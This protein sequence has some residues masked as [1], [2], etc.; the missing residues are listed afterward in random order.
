M[1]GSALTVWALYKC[2]AREFASSGEISLLVKLLGKSSTS[3]DNVGHACLA[4][5]EDILAVHRK[6]LLVSDHVG[7]VEVLFFLAPGNGERVVG[8]ES[9]RGDVQVCMLTGAECP[10]AS[11]A[12]RDAERIA[13]QNLDV[14]LG[15]TI[16]NVAL[17]ETEETPDTL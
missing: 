1:H 10:G 8:P 4:G 15:T 7:D 5:F 6:T 17:D 16:A 9:D 14:G 13:G 11:H 12:Y 3:A 2:R